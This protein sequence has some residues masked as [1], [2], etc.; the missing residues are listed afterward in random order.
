MPRVVHFEICA[1]NPK[2]ASK[3]YKSVFGWK[4]QTWSGDGGDY[5]LVSTGRKGPGID[6][7]ILKR[8]HKNDRT[9]NTVDVK[10]LPAAKWSPRR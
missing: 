10:S 5:H 8:S 7:G 1:R 9:V 3:F 2:R 4:I 6:G